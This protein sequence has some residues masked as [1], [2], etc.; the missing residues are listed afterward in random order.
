[1]GGAGPD[2]LI[3][4]DRPNVLVGGGGDDLLIGLAGNDLIVGGPGRD[5]IDAGPGSDRVAIRDGQV[6]RAR[7]GD[8][9]DAV[10]ADRSDKL[11]G[12]ESKRAIAVKIP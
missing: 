7:C 5:R 11:I 12:C 6:D 2:T 9:R 1:V 4:D 10:D 8:G 3:G